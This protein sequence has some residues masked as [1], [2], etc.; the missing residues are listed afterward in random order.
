[1]VLT[2][3]HMAF[4]IICH[5]WVPMAMAMVESSS[6]G[7]LSTENLASVGSMVASSGGSRNGSNIVDIGTTSAG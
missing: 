6:M 7:N 4:I 5:I 2:I 1:M 3:W